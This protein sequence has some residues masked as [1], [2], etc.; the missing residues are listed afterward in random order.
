MTEQDC[1][2]FLKERG[3]DNPLYNKFKRCGCWFC[4]KQSM[5]SLRIL[6]ADYPELWQ[7]LLEWQKDSRVTFKPN[8]TVQDLEERFRKEI[9]EG[10]K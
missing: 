8:Y 4:P 1:L 2:N 10:E 3:L 6:R 7:Q 5:D 9:L